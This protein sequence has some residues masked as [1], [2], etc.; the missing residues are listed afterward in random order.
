[1]A[2]DVMH[3]AIRGGLTPYDMAEV[4][5]HNDVAELLR[6]NGGHE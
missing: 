5:R 1:M 6:Q 3:D 2:F 4:K